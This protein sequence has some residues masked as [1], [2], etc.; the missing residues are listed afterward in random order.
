MIGRR[1]YGEAAGFVDGWRGD[2]D[3]EPLACIKLCCGRSER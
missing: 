2:E 1:G 3:V